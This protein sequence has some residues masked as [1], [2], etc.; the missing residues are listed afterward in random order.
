MKLN[1]L[2]V[3]Y[4]VA[5]AFPVQSLEQL[6][7]FNQLQ[8]KPLAIRSK[9]DCQ[10]LVRLVNRY[11]KQHQQTPKQLIEHPP[12]EVMEETKEAS[13]L[14]VCTL[15]KRRSRSRDRS[16]VCKYL[17]NQIESFVGWANGLKWLHF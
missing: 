7:E 9:Q 6:L 14:S 15:E 13:S 16:P 17:F 2:G 12:A 1:L 8:L 10:S 5:R 11:V 3:H 4:E